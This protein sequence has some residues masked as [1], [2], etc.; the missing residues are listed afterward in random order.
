MR[1]LQVILPVAY[2]ATFLVALITTNIITNAGDVSTNFIKYI[3]SVPSAF[4]T[5]KNVVFVKF[6]KNHKSHVYFLLP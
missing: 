1:H 2:P 5:E 4:A 6:V 3:T